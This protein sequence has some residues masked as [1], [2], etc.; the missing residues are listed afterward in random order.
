MPRL[1]D[2]LTLPEGLK[3][4]SDEELSSLAGEVREVIV[5]AVSENGGH[6]APSLGVVELAIALHK[7]FDSPTDKILWDVGHQSY[8]HKILTGRYRSFGTLRRFGGVS[9]FP[10]M[11][12]TGGSGMC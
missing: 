10:K 4:L 6:L 1:L 5:D 12:E 3:E 8:A 2:S 11:S 9:G 7:T